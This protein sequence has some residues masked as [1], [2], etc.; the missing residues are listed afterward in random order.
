MLSLQ[1]AVHHRDDGFFVSEISYD[2]RH[3]AH[4]ERAAG[5]Q[6]AVS[7][8]QLIAVLRR[9]CKRGDQHTRFPDA[10]FQSFHFFIFHDF[11]RVL[12]ERFQFV[13]GKLV[14][15]RFLRVDPLLCAHKE[16]IV[17]GQAQVYAVCFHGS[18]PLFL[19]AV[20]IVRLFLSDKLSNLTAS[21][22]AVLHPTVRREIHSWISDPN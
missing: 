11:E 3:G 6:S 5:S 16:L 2:H 17:P 10:F 8:Y 15:F 12:L 4:T 22:G 18:S 9:S 14:H 1:I 21:G 19:R 7:G 13:K 20:N